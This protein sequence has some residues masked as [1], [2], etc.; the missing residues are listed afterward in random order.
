[1]TEPN[2]IQNE[3]VSPRRESSPRR[4]ELFG[5]MASPSTSKATARPR[6]TPKKPTWM[7]DYVVSNDS[8]INDDET[9]PVHFVGI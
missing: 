3:V 4:E 1:M 6:R 5:G 8:D 7:K 9:S 2:R